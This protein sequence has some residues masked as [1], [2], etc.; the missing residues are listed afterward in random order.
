MVWVMFAANNL[1]HDEACLVNYRSFTVKIIIVMLDTSMMAEIK[2]MQ[3]LLLINA[4]RA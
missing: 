1:F 2:E 4:S 3:V